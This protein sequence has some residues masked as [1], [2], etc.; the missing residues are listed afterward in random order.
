MYKSRRGGAQAPLPCVSRIF[1]YKSGEGGAQAPLP[2]DPSRASLG[3]FFT[4]PEKGVR[5]HRYPGTPPVRLSEFF[6]QVRRRGCAGTATP[7]PLP[8]VSRN[9][10]YKSGEGGAQAP[11]P[12]DPSRAS[13]GIFF[14]SP[15]K[16]VR[17]HRYPGTPPVRLS[18]FFLQVRRRGCAGTA[19]PGPLPCVSQNFFYKS[20]EGG[21]H[22]PLHWVPSQTNYLLAGSRA[23]MCPAPPGRPGRGLFRYQRGGVGTH[24]H[25]GPPLIRLIVGRESSPHAPGLGPDAWPR[26]RATS[27]G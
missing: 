3:I 26:T 1:F 15:E 18:E 19:T 6:L 7:G 4:S 2:R 20:G 13:L 21:A 8:C 27:T 17:R 12:R 16:G 14:T 25:P 11:L 5:R 10:F 22:A 24:R 23:L 9:F